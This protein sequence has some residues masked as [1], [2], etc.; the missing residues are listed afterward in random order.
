MSVHFSPINLEFSGS[1]PAGC[2]KGA[3]SVGFWFLG[4]ARVGVDQYPSYGVEGRKKMS[5]LVQS[6]AAQLN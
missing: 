5:C 2:A 6:A 4:S 1:G 3:V